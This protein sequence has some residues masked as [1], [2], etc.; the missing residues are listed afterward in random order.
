M[1]SKARYKWEI[2]KVEDIHTIR[3]Y[4]TERRKN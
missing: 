3:E 1:V 2:Y 4:N